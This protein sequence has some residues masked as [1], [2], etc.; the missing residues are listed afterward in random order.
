[1]DIDYE[2]LMGIKTSV[3]QQTEE[4][5]SIL[6]DIKVYPDPNPVLLRA[7]HYVAVGCDLK[8]LKKL[9]EALKEVLGPSPVSVLCIAEVSLTYMDVQSADALISWFP[10]LGKGSHLNTRGFATLADISRYTILCSGAILSR[11][12]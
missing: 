8:N 4:L 12:A 7:S 6:G 9:E 11:W 10:T 3:L 2:K 5:K 1:M